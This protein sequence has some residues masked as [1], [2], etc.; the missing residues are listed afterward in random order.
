MP[1]TKSYVK[2]FFST[3]ILLSLSFLF[4]NLIQILTL[5]WG[6]VLAAT[7]ASNFFPVVWSFSDSELP[8]ASSR[9]KI[10]RFFSNIFSSS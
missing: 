9:S 5:C 3:L 1:L 4:Y 2:I 6:G 10:C 7:F 8:L